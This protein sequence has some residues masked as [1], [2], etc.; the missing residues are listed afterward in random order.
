MTGGLCEEDRDDQS[1]TKQP[2]SQVKV[3]IYMTQRT[4]QQRKALEVFFKRLA[5]SLNA[6]GLDMRIVI[7]P[8]VEIPWTQENV[9]EWLWRPIQK[10]LY[11]KSST[12]ELDKQMEID[13]IHEVLMHHLGEKFGLEYIDFP[14][15][16]TRFPDQPGFHDKIAS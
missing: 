14:H 8:E 2:H 1:H 5:D 12:T 6:A 7:K 13:K 3:G 10:A 15:D 16:E 4:D 11:N 9:K